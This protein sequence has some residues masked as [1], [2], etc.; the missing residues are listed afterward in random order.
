MEL[1]AQGQAGWGLE[2]E[3]GSTEAERT[4]ANACRARKKWSWGWGG[5]RGSYQDLGNKR[6]NPIGRLI[7]GPKGAPPIPSAPNPAPCTQPPEW[8]FEATQPAQFASCESRDVSLSMV[9]NLPIAPPP[10][11]KQC[12]F[13]PKPL[14]AAQWGWWV[15]LRRRQRT[16]IVGE[17]AP[18][19]DFQGEKASFSTSHGDRGE[20]K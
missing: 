8:A 3:E 12:P 7:S 15:G 2:K 19:R 17:V 9:L 18:A 5:G 11:K 13:P 16:G 1:S 10:P 6:E 4:Q 20:H 14:P